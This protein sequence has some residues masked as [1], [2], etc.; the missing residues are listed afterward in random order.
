MIDPNLA[1]V[2]RQLLRVTAREADYLARTAARVRAQRADLDWVASLPNNDDR[3]ELLDAFVSRYGRLQ[4][5]LGDKLVPTMLKA[6]LEQTGSQID[7]LLRA[8]KLGWLAS[9]EEWVALRA[10]R[11]RL[12]HEY[13]ESPERL[14]EA[15]QTALS[16]VDLLLRVQRRLQEEALRHNWIDGND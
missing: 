14:L 5:T 10:I 16:G 3:S 4:D 7:N 11:N 8:E 1:L 2:L 15:L 6:S 12:V 9:T 13:V